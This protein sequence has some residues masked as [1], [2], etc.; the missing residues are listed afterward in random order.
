MNSSNNSFIKYGAVIT[1]GPASKTKPF[2]LKTLALPPSSGCFYIN[3]T[4][5]FFALSLNAA[6]IPPKPEP[7]T[8]EFIQLIYII[9]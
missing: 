7:I 9:F 8:I 1:V 6:A 2:F 3:V 5:W 4:L